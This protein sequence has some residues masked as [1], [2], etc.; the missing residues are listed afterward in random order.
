MIA[1]YPKSTWA[2]RDEEGNLYYSVAL[3]EDLYS[4]PVLFWKPKPKII[5]WSYGSWEG[6]IETET[7]V[8]DEEAFLLVLKEVRDELWISI[9]LVQ[10][11]LDNGVK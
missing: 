6:Y 7:E 1:G 11:N 8:S 3:T 9:C 4:L 10:K 5:N 2:R